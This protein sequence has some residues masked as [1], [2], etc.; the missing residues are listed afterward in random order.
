MDFGMSIGGSGSDYITV[1]D[2]RK[3]PDGRSW[4]EEARINRGEDIES[5]ST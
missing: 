5:G 2:G 3:G 4:N 1:A